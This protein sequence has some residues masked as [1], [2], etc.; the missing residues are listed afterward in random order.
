MKESEPSSIQWMVYDSECKLSCLPRIVLR[1]DII[2]HMQN[3]QIP[4]FSLEYV[5]TPKIIQPNISHFN[6][7][8]CLLSRCSDCY[9]ERKK[10]LTLQNGLQES[11]TTNETNESGVHMP[12]LL[13]FH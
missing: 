10:P 9:A 5:F 13:P 7:A 1:I 3:L 12:L 11:E 2:T 6:Q 8:A 4:H